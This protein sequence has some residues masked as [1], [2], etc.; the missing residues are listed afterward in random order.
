MKIIKLTQNKFTVVDDTDYKRLNQHKW[1]FT[2]G[3]AGRK[4][5]TISGKRVNSYMHWEVV[6]KPEKGFEIDHI[7]GDT[8]DNR[9]ENLRLAT[10][11]Q[12]K[13]NRGK[14]KNNTSGIKGICWHKDRRKWH[15]RI[16]IDGKRIHLG[17]FPTKELASQAY[18][19]AAKKYHKQFA[20]YE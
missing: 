11:A 7:N 15:A 6:G 16:G 8:L 19:D 9:K 14:L 17:L 3:Y 4:I 2:K 13:H 18:K 5:A 10:H 1:Y 12:N 20:Y